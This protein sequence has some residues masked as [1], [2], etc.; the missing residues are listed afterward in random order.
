MSHIAHRLQDH[1]SFPFAV[2][3]L[4]TA[5]KQH[6]QVGGLIE[7]AF[8]SLCVDLRR[9]HGVPLTL[10]YLVLVGH[11]SRATVATIEHQ[12]HPTPMIRWTARCMVVVI[13]YLPIPD[14][15]KYLAFNVMPP[16]FLWLD[17]SGTAKEHMLLEEGQLQHV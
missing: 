2:T 17:N 10:L 15:K 14:P 16:A 7:V 12:F 9:F 3:N 1:R 5:R 13:D 11:S 6:L 8:A 4:I